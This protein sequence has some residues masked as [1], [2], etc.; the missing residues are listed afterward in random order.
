MTNSRYLIAFA[1]LL[2]T[3][4][5]GGG[6]ADSSSLSSSSDAGKVLSAQES[7][8]RDIN[9]FINTVA[10]TQSTDSDANL[11]GI[12]IEAAG[13]IRSENGLVDGMSTSS[14]TVDRIY[15]VHFVMDNGNSI[16]VS[17]CS[18]ALTLY[19][20]HF[21][22]QGNVIW[23]NFKG[24][25]TKP[26]GTVTHNKQI[27]FGTTRYV[28]SKTTSTTDVSFSGDYTSQWI[29]LNTSLQAAIGKLSGSGLSKEVACAN[30]LTSTGEVNGD[31]SESFSVLFRDK[32]ADWLS[33]DSS[34]GDDPPIRT[35]KTFTLY[36]SG[37]KV[38]FKL[39]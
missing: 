12:W 9:S 33:S 32:N 14:D 5:G 20:F 13:D 17:D 35:G 36:V 27:D 21:D 30:L 1:S 38:Q 16:D 2:L 34:N 11:T 31:D 7:M 6:G 8:A 10:S 28:G 22:E 25:G 18:T 29:K 24:D 37:A 23:S 19:T 15:H 3:A 4:C 26:V 39:Y